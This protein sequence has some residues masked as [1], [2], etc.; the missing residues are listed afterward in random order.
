MANW[1]DYGNEKTGH[2]LKCSACGED[3]GDNMW[4]A[5]YWYCPECGVHMEA[6]EEGDEK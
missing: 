5:E 4:L 3:Y 1:I 6:E 2:S